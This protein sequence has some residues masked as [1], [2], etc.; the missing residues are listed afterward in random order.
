MSRSRIA[1]MPIAENIRNTL[2]AYNLPGKAFEMMA[3]VFI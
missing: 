2:K 1:T 3:P